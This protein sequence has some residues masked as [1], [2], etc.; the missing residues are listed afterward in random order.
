MS[1]KLLS[2]TPFTDN[3]TPKNTMNDGPKA[4]RPGFIAVKVVTWPLCF[5]PASC[6]LLV[7]C[8]YDGCCNHATTSNFTALYDEWF[9]TRVGF[10]EGENTNC[11]EEWTDIWNSD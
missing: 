1:K 3:P 2:V 4:L 8:L 6:C 5:L 7:S 10:H 11:T 9:F